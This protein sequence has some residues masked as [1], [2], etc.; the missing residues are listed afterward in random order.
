L[1]AVCADSEFCDDAVVAAVPAILV[2]VAAAAATFAET[3]SA[4]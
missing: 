2:V 1:A 4:A 3:G